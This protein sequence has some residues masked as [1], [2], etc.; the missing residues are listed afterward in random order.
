MIAL[1]KTPKSLKNHAAIAGALGLALV[2][3]GCKHTVSDAT[4]NSNVQSKL[5]SDPRSPA[6]PSRSRPPTAW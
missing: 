4:L 3:A 6:S 1:S 5:S 2:L